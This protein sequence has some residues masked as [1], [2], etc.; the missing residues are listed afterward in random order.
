MRILLSIF[1]CVLLCGFGE[2]A[3]QVQ[4][5]N[6]FAL[7]LYKTLKDKQSGNLFFS[8]Y[9]ISSAVAMTSVGAKEET[10]SEIDSVFHFDS[11]PH[12]LAGSFARIN[13]SMNTVQGT[14]EE[15]PQ[16]YLANRIWMQ[17]ETPFEIDFVDTLDREFKSG[18]DAL[19]FEEN[20][21]D[22][23]QELNRWVA[24]NT[25]GKIQDLFPAGSIHEGTRLVLASAIYLSA[26]WKMQFDK[27]NTTHE[28]FYLENDNMT[29]VEMMNTTSFFNFFNNEELALLELPYGLEKG[30]ESNLAMMVLLPKQVDGL[31]QIEQTLTPDALNTW[32]ESM[33]I[34]DVQVR[35]PKFQMS[36]DLSLVETL[37]GMG[38][39][40]A[41]T[42]AADFSGITGSRDIAIDNILHKA[43]IGVDEAGTEAA[44]ATGVTVMLTSLIESPD[45]DPYYFLADHPFL[46]LIV[47]RNTSSI[48]FMGRYASP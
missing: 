37:D 3:D 39:H 7:D 5:N 20:P 28:M 15:F 11:N 40:Q 46:F 21:E 8:P 43:Y 10:K 16:L 23:R 27:S 44:A 24:E 18:I 32:M 47:D 14:P 13:E 45:E 19:N 38:M 25:R 6:A 33:T 36:Q 26:P 41:F 4:G 2:A 17:V 48:L 30:G 31:A 22:S 34:Q 42:S 1:C 9:S 12:M 35:L 29:L